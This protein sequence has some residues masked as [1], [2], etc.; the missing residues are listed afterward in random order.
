MPK[1]T[2]KNIIS[3]S[4]TK[5]MRT[6]LILCSLT[7][8]FKVYKVPFNDL[9]VFGIN[10]PSNLVDVSLFITISYSFYSY[11]VSWVG[12]LLAYKLWFQNNSI[13]SMF[14][15]EMK[16]DKSFLDGGIKLLNQL[17]ELDRRDKLP[18]SK[19]GIDS[20]IVKEY[21]LFKL[22]IELYNE[23]LITTIG[24]F[25]KLN[26][27]I[28]YYIFIEHFLFPAILVVFSLILLF[29]YGAFIFPIIS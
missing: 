16:L 5:K 13:L 10:I 24:N 6:I 2:D 26:L 11:I 4:T 29:K 20:D 7:I 21:E 18:Q 14:S 17:I 1:L 8:L 27:Y 15:T 28:K 19:V 25:N 22:N 12:D 3:E 9:K 23:R